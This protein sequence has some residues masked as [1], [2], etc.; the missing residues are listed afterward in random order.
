[1]SSANESQLTETEDGFSIEASILGFPINIAEWP[2]HFMIEQDTYKM[3]SRDKDGATYRHDASGR[4]V[5]VL[6]D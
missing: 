5:E 4:K 2:E 3:S 6:N 1:V